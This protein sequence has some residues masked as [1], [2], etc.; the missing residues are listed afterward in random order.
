MFTGTGTSVTGCK[1]SM[2]PRLWIHVNCP[3][4]LG[5]PF[6]YPCQL[7]PR[8]SRRQGCWAWFILIPGAGKW[9]GFTLT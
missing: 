2:C 9:K 5:F 6:F 3:Q 8:A 1:A 4:G 7:P